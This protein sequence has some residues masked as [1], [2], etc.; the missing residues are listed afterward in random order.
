LE[1]QYSIQESSRV[2]VPEAVETPRLLLRRPT[3][4]DTSFLTSLFQNEQVKRFL[5]GAL[6]P[7]AAEERVARLFRSW[8]AIDG[9]TWG[10]WVVCEKGSNESVGICSL[11]FF[12]TEV[13][14][15]YMLAPVYWGHGYATESATACL[16]YGFQTLQLDHIIG[17]TQEPNLGSQRVLEKLGM[18]HVRDLWKWNAPQ[19][20]YQV[21]RTEWLAKQDRSETT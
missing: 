13:E 14:V 21:T 9:Q 12:E 11:G 5:G 19:R 17:V 3:L 4:T 15:A 2:T 6:S 7:Q 1:E 20:L 8:E 16:A 18:R 10:E